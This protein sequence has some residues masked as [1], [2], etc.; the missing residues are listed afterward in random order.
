M[1]FAITTQNANSEYIKVYLK[2]LLIS[3]LA[4][5]FLEVCKKNIAFFLISPITKEKLKGNNILG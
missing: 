2:F 4:V 5:L 1:Q 3:S